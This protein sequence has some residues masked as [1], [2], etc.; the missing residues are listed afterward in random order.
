M[1][2]DQIL[3]YR[4]EDFTKSREQW[5]SGEEIMIQSHN[6]RRLVYILLL[7]G[8]SVFAQDQSSFT[9]R[10]I[11]PVSH[12]DL[13]NLTLDLVIDYPNRLLTATATNT[14][15]AS[16]D[17]ITKLRFHAGKYTKV[18]SVDLDGQ[19][20]Q[21]VRDGE[22]I[23]A[24]C[25]PTRKGQRIVAAIH[26]HLKHSDRPGKLEEEGWH[27]QEPQRNDPSRIGFWTKGEPVLTREWAVSWDY[28]N[29][30]T[31]TETRTTVPADWTVIGNGIMESDKPSGG[32]KSHTVVWKMTK[33]HA[34]Y[35]TSL[36]AG[37]FDVQKDSWHGMPL[38]YA[39]PR[40][41]KPGST[42]PDDQ[43]F[44]IFQLRRNDYG[45]SLAYTCAHTKDMLTFFSDKFGVKYPWPRYAQTFAYDHNGAMENVSATTLGNFLTNP[46][47]GRYGADTVI[48]HELAHQWF[49]DLVTCRDWGELW[50]N[51]SLATLA[52]VLWVRHERGQD[53]AQ[54]MLYYWN[55]GYLGESRSYMR[56]IATDR[57]SDPGVMFDTHSYSKGGFLLESLRRRLGDKKF[58]AGL[59]LY[60]LQNQNSPVTTDLL[61]SA[62]SKEAGTDLQPWFNQWILKPGHPLIDWSWSWDEA[63]REVVVKVK[64]VQ[65]IANGTPIYDIPAKVGLISGSR[66]DRAPIHLQS[67]EQEFRI[68]S[69][70]RPDAVLLD[71]DH[72]ILR[73][74]KKN[75]W[76]ESV[77]PAIVRF[78]PDCMDRS[79][80]L[81]LML[82]GKPSDSAVALAVQVLGVDK[83][84]EPAF[85][86]TSSLAAL[87]RAELRS[88]WETELKH[89]HF[90][91]RSQAIAA[92]RG[93]PADSG[94][95]AKL[96]ALVNDL[97]PYDVVANAVTALGQI[98][99]TG[100]KQLIENQ[101]ETS[102]IRTIR[103]AALKVLIENKSAGAVDLLF[104]SV[105]ETQPYPAQTAGFEVLQDLAVDDPR[106]IPLLRAKLNSDDYHGLLFS[107]VAVVKKWKIK[108]LLP[109]LQAL[110][111]RVPFAKDFVKSAITAIQP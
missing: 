3:D 101:A 86:D 91:R 89:A 99:F 61:V 82:T 95:N 53:A 25:R 17:G 46:R 100:S 80:A 56:P 26:Y 27:W 68:R 110:E 65:D 43:G 63:K 51:E 13:Q 66:V 44:D 79:A 81:K 45:A 38:T 14:L 104:K 48:A 28:P 50:L 12:Y 47:Q 32:G 41:P 111:Q 39:A 107:A 90:G 83:H 55:L 58:F 98:D 96:R 10:Q 97:E 85:I 60:L 6:M 33:P 15:I 73:Q 4:R 40:G 20:V 54:R 16:E 94:T 30:L 49:G 72:D 5:N 18:D 57:Y 31:T 84:F 78:A 103:A 75:P 93:L 69:A 19:P 34:T 59:K 62:M 24:E 74:I 52:E 23:L 42:A 106:L 11:P 76:T 7:L 35:L 2:G 102:F 22:G 36:V 70:K 108:E 105:D 87:K 1:T 88:F 67:I 77:L 64:Q 29:D 9:P 71:P 37:L 21:F 8:S 92:L 109:E